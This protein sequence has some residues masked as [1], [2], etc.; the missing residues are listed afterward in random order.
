[1]VWRP[2]SAFEECLGLKY[3]RKFSVCSVWSRLESGAVWVG[4]HR[5]EGFHG[6]LWSEDVL[7]VVEAG[8]KRLLCLFQAVFQVQPTSVQK[9]TLLESLKQ[10]V[11]MSECFRFEITKL[12]E[13]CLFVDWSSQTVLKQLWVMLYFTKISNNSVVLKSQRSCLKGSFTADLWI[14]VLRAPTVWTLQTKRAI[15]VSA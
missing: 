11:F 4:L 15:N 9:W 13:R 5:A 8:E 12:C 6:V 10:K 3:P 14:V 1:M 7:A 2:L